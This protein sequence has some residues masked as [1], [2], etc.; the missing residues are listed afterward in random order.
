M[1][2]TGGA[3][4]F[5]IIGVFGLSFAVVGLAMVLLIIGAIVRRA[6]AGRDVP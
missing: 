5:T 6:P 4:F 3:F 1:P 2:R